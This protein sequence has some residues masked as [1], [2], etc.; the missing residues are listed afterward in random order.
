MVYVCFVPF[1]TLGHSEMRHCS[2]VFNDRK[3]P[4]TVCMGSDLRNNYATE[5][6]LTC[7]LDVHC[8]GFILIYLYIKI[9]VDCIFD[10]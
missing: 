4:R 5:D 3:S 6:S 10:I 8:L 2:I 9:S 7:A 1:N